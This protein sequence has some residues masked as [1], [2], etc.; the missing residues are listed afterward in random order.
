MKRL[1]VNFMTFAVMATALTLTAC[2][3]DS[4]GDGDGN[5]DG[6]NNGGTGSSIVVGENILSGTLTGE[7]TLEAKE[8]IL[9]GTVV[10]ENG[11]RLN[12]PAGTTIKAREGFS[13]YL[14]VAQGGK[15]YADGTA[16]KPIVF[17]ANSTTPTS[18]YWGGIIINGKAPI[19]GSN[20]NKSDTGLTE[21]DNNY[22]YGGNV[23][24]DNSGSLTYVKICYAGAR[25]TADIEH[26]GL[27]LN[28]VGNG[29]K[30]ENIYILESADDAVEFFGGTV[31]VDHCVVV[32]C[33]DDSFD[34]TEGWSG[35]ATNL[36]AY[37]TDA[38]CDCLIEA[39]NN[40]DNFDATPVA[41]PTLRNLYL[42]G[43]GSSENKRGIRLRAGTRANIDGAKVA[44]KP[45]PLTIETTQT[46]DALA[47]GT[48]V[49]KNVQIAGVLKNDVTGGKYLSANFLTGQG[50][51][52]NAQIATT[53]DDVAGDLSFAWLN[54][55]W[56][57]AVQ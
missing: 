23:D 53:W 48:S 13:S 12:I 44:G 27:T 8:Y 56:V 15:L 9:N 4:D 45:N 55:A 46:D 14:L 51:A 47:N 54:D 17:T 20:A 42:V 52:E 7:Q 21:I 41:H 29:T 1:F 30:I 31:N 25:S 34:W 33:T 11:G 50:N 6:G 16:D 18:G 35:T 5:G 40:G 37:Q 10:I 38:S 19:S 36:V 26:N 24:N 43:N 32:D 22:K 57:T 3:S 39:D 28:G 2:S 49:L